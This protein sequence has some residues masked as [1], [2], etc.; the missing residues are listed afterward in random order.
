MQEAGHIVFLIYSTLYFLFLSLYY[1]R[2]SKQHNS[3][4]LILQNAMSFSLVTDAL[5]MILLWTVTNLK[6]S[7]L[8]A[9]DDCTQKNKESKKKKKWK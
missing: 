8:F 1:K 7:Q 5:L 4:L 9:A 2:A 3:L 6:V